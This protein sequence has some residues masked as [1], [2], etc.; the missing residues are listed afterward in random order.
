MKT[1]LTFLLSGMFMFFI[2]SNASAFSLNP[3]AEID[4]LPGKTVF[5]QGDPIL[6]E[7]YGSIPNCG[8]NGGGQYW[9]DASGRVTQIFDDIQDSIR[10]SRS[11]L[12]LRARIAQ[13]SFGYNT[14]THSALVN[15]LRLALHELPLGIHISYERAL[16]GDIYGNL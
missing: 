3:T 4:I 8:Y 12:E 9:Y 10:I 16:Q 14:S 1:L 6:L 2:H 5:L 7:G 15:L 11:N 13:V